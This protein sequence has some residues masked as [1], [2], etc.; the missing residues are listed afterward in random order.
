MKISWSKLELLQHE[1]TFSIAADVRSST[2]MEV[3]IRILQIAKEAMEE[4][5]KD[6]PTKEKPK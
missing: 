3:L 1:V 2:E 4:Y 6:F 5:E